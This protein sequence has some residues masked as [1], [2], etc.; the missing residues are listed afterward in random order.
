[1]ITW[2]EAVEQLRRD[3]AQ[4]ELVLSCYYD[5]PLLGAAERFAASEEWV[6]LQEWLPPRGRVLELGAGRGIASWAFA[7]AGWEVTALEPDPSDVVGAGAIRKLA[8][9]TGVTIEVAEEWGESLPFPPEQFDVVYGRAVF[10][11]ARDLDAFCQEA[12]RVLKPGGN[13]ILTREHVLSREEDLAQFFKTHHLHKLY[14][15]EN[16]FT[17]DRYLGAIRSGGLEVSRVIG[18]K[19]SPVNYAPESTEAVAR[20][21]R[22]R[23]KKRIGFLK[24]LFSGWSQAQFLEEA[25]LWEEKMKMPG[26]LYSFIAVKR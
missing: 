10:H 7:K 19:S 4:S 16:A 24:A 14:G 11:H 17:L 26:R 1:M 9:D 15:G 2:E 18:P 13:L 23:R 22:Q 8:R 3:P 12:A 6:A 20:T 25:A 21:L 5:D